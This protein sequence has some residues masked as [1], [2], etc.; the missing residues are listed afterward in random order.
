L[1]VS[2][3]NLTVGLKAGWA[4]HKSEDGKLFYAKEGE[5]SVWEKLTGHD[6]SGILPLSNAIKDMG[7]LACADGRHYH[8]WS[9][10]PLYGVESLDGRWKTDEPANLSIKGNEVF[11][12]KSDNVKSLVIADGEV[13]LGKWVAVEH[14]QQLCFKMEGKEDIIWTKQPEFKYISTSC[15]IPAQNEDVPIILGICQHCGQ[16]KEQH[17]AKGAMTSLNISDNDIGQVVQ[18]PEL[19]KQHGVTYQKVKSGLGANLQGVTG[20]MLYWDKDAKS[21]GEKCPTYCGRRIGVIALADAIKDM[22]A[23]TSLNLSSNDLEAE[24]AKIV[25]E[26]IKVIVMRLRSFWYHFHVHLITG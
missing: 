12:F 10:N 16:R 19:M 23:L 11:F 13:K 1:N 17:E 15:D 26:T 6:M 20:M 22:G 8:E 24:G 18:D 2:K 4:E 21:L 9:L 25:A 7:A 5:A 3:N 14:M